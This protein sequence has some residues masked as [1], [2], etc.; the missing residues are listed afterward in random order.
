MYFC[1]PYTEEL[2][3]TARLVEFTIFIGIF[4]L[5]PKLLHA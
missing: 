1:A 3:S 2:M 4:N 5:V